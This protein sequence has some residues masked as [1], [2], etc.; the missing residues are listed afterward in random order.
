MVEPCRGTLYRLLANEFDA[1]GAV[2]VPDPT[3]GDIAVETAPSIANGKAAGAWNVSHAATV[4][5][6]LSSHQGALDLSGIDTLDTTGAWLLLKASTRGVELSAAKPAH[7]ELMEAVAARTQNRGADPSPIKEHGSWL[8]FVADTGAW[9]VGNLKQGG[10][11]LGFLGFVMDRLFRLMMNPTKF[12]LTSTVHHMQQVGLSAVPIILLMSFLIGIVLSYQGAFQLRQFGAE[13]FVVDLLTL[14]ILREL[15]VLLTAIMVAGRSGSAFTAEIG[16]MKVR[17]EIDAMHTMGIEPV[18]VLVLP[19]LIALVIMLPI[20]SFL[21]DIAGLLGG[22]L[23]AWNTLDIAPGAFITRF[24]D[25]VTAA[26][27]WTGIAKAPFFALIIALV[28]CYEGLQVHGSAESVGRQTTRSV[29]ESI[30]LVI[31][32]DGIF[33]VFFALMG[34]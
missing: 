32:V 15:G 25:A 13:I 34:L 27:F 8:D 30:F 11:I 31:V 20:L 28:G 14:S 21:A 4:E 6:L 24:S 5:A 3:L 12:R 2:F 17:E 1:K 7:T 26:H 16:S 23:M 18:D 29:V 33:S 19:R 9:T 10:A 22:A